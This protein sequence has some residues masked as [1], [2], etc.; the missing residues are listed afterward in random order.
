MI[1]G[2]GAGAGRAG[3]PRE[4]NIKQIRQMKKTFILALTLFAATAAQA[5]TATS[6]LKA[7]IEWFKEDPSLEKGLVVLVPVCLFVLAAVRSMLLRALFIG[8]AAA[9]LYSV[10]AK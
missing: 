9:A 2:R 1:S 7:A 5:Q 4:C 10:M 8:A 6:T 3:C